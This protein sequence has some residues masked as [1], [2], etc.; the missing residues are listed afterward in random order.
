MKQESCR[1]SVESKIEEQV[2]RSTGLHGRCIYQWRQDQTLSKL[3][4][5]WRSVP[6]ISLSVRIK[7]W[8]RVA[9]QRA[10]DNETGGK[11]RSTASVR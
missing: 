7:Q 2:V 6:E 8:L 3:A 1:E 11:Q 9:G 10:T 4:N 5:A